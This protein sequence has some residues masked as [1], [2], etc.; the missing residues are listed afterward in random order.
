[1]TADDFVRRLNAAV[2][3]PEDLHAGLSPQEID[4]RLFVCRELPPL[5][6]A[7]PIICSISSPAMTLAQSRS[8]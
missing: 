3:K 1:M 4:V 7:K 2:P 6:S 8:A 5:V